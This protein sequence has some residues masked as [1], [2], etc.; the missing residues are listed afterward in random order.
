[1]EPVTAARFEGFPLLWN[2]AQGFA[3]WATG[4]LRAVM[5]PHLLLLLAFLLWSWRALGVPVPFA[6]LGLLACPMIVVHLQAS[7][8]DLPVALGLGFAFLAGVALPLAPPGRRALLVLAWL[9][10][11]LIAGNSKHQGLIGAAAVA[12]AVLAAAMADPRAARRWAPL[13]LL[14]LA[15]AGLTALRNLVLLGNPLYPVEVALAG[16]V[17]FAGPESAEFGA[18]RPAY[19]LGGWYPLGGLGP[20]AF[21]LS[22]T[23]LDWTLRGAPPWYSLDAMGGL[24]SLIPPGARTGG[25]GSGFVLANLALLAAQFARWRAR[26]PLQRRLALG[27]LALLVVA[28]FL[29][30]GHELRYWLFIPVVLAMVNLRFLAGLAPR[31]ALLPV[32][33]LAAALHG[34]ALAVLSPQGTFFHE[35]PVT[36]AELA[37]RVPPAV[38]AAFAEGRPFCDAEDRRLFRF[39]TAATGLAGRLSQNPADCVQNR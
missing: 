33:L 22:A 17:L 9:A 19:R 20:L 13:F 3:W 6:I 31:P 38:R 26:D 30:R 14:G 7:Y 16:H 12:L 39:S 32:L 1:V 10:G 29:P 5:L 25:W 34:L 8:L 15:L 27:A 21:W 4:A 35:R 11:L 28:T 18:D 37:A 24:Q 23:E 36:Q 2:A